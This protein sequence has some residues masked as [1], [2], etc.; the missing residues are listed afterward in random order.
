[1]DAFSVR[2][3]AMSITLLITTVAALVVAPPAAAAPSDPS[4]PAAIL[5]TYEGRDLRIRKDIGSTSAY[6]RHAITYESGDLTISGIMNKPRGKGPFPVVVLA[7]GY[8]DPA[9]YVTGQGFPG[10]GLART[11]RLCRPACRLPQPRQL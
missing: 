5:E 2:T 3:A 10:A 7:H 4:I 11:Q 6:T 9:V 8:I 1:M